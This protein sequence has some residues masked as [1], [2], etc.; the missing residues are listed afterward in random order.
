VLPE[1]LTVAEPLLPPAQLTLVEA[2]MVAVAGV[3]L[4]TL[5]A[6]CTVQPAAS[7]TNTVYAPPDNPD[8]VEALPPL[9]DQSY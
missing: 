4:D 8:A 2:V 1:T 7:V 9:G 6:A 5:T 3:V